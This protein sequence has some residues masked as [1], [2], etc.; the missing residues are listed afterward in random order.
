MHQDKPTDAAAELEALPPPEASVAHA[1][2]DED[3][4]VA[5]RRRLGGPVPAL[6]YVMMAVA[7]LLGVG[8]GSAY[9]K[10][11]LDAPNRVVPI[12]F[13]FVLEAMAAAWFGARRLGRP[14]TNDQR[15]RVAITY[16]FVVAFVLAPLFA[17]GWMPGSQAL[18]ER[19]EGLSSGGVIAALGVVA[20]G[21]V[22]VALARYLVLAL[23][24]PLLRSSKAS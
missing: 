13:A 6:L 18:L 3:P 21:L 17:L 9:S 8:L 16:T 24:S 1:D 4:A 23:V 22:T 12:A 2:A 19:L 14:L 15:V 5:A 11:V 10:L 7:G 20:L